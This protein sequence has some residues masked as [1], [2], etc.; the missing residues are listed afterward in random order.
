MTQRG[1]SAPVLFNFLHNISNDAK[2]IMRASLLFAI[3][4][5][6]QQREDEKYPN[7]KG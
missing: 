1:F 6:R 2:L 4:Q 3:K 7:V 5:C